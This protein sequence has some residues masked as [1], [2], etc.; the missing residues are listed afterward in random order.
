LE[1]DSAAPLAG[2][3][4]LD[5]TRLLPGPVATLHLADLGAEVIKIEDTGAGDYARGMG[6]MRAGAS[7]FYELV[8]RNKRSLRLDLKQ[9]EGVEAFLRLAREADIVVESFRP[10]VVDK[11]GVGWARVHAV[12]PR[13]VYCS[14]TGWGQSGPWAARAGHDLNFIAVAGV[15]DQIGVAG[16]PPAL[17]NFQIGDLL[18]GALTAL[19]GV[20]AALLAAR[21]SGQGRHLDIAMADAVFAHAL[22]PFA[23]L[24]GEGRVAPRGEDDL[25]GGLACYAVY[26]TADGRHMACAPLEAKFWKIFCAA[27]GRPDLEP[28]HLARGEQGARLKA[29]IAGIFARRTRSEW[30]ALFEPLDCC[31]T[32][33]LTLEESCANE[34][35]RARGMLQEV[36]GMPQFATPFR[37]SGFAPGA[38]RPAPEAGADSDDILRGAGYGAAEIAALRARGVI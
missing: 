27:L 29:E 32:P 25:T 35:L 3:R 5:L 6:P 33:V 30:V 4:V 26:E 19:S 15:L 38:A 7:W 18:G 37:L 11:L 16:G 34:Q 8:N 10:G 20:L 9:P 22:F 23:Q 28:L 2:V 21:T 1:A 13:L 17:P 14:I 24:Q 12:N 31:V 36:A